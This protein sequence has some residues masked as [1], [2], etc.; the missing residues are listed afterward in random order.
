MF[1]LLISLVISYYLLNDVEILKKTLHS[2]LPIKYKN[3]IAI[4]G[5]EINNIIKGFIQGQ[6]FTSLVV[7]MLITVGLIITKVKFPFVLGIIGGITNIIPYFGPIIGA[8]PAVI[9]ASSQS[10]F[11]GLKCAL[12]F[13]IVQQID[14]VF[15]SPKITEK[16]IGLHPITTIFVVLVGGELFGILGMLVAV[17]I[18]ASLKIITKRIIERIV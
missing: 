8:I 4:V 9:V 17:P 2:L 7:G 18:F 6:I 1:G 10:I 11:T 12:V 14:N 3:D 5:R 13:V 16:K 15:I